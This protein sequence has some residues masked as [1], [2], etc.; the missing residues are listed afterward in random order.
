MAHVGIHGFAASHRQKDTT[1]HGDPTPA[2]SRQQRDPVP[3]IDGGDHRG[4]A[5]NADDTQNGD[6]REPQQHY[7]TG[8]LGDL[9][10]TADLDG[11]QGEQDR[12]RHKDDVRLEHIGRDV[13]PFE[14][15]QYRNCRC[16]DAVAVEQ[17]RS[18]QPHDDEDAP[19]FRPV[20]AGH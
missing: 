19:A 17:R 1:E 9:R 20:R 10:G 3:R 2:V 8:R 7:R 16:D 14:G 5:R 18:E 13:E 11:E 6:D 4:V 12:D 15:A